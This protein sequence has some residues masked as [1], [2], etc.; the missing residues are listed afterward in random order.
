MH[1]A[2]DAINGVSGTISCMHEIAVAIAAAVEE[3]GV[4]TREIAHSIQQVAQGTEQVSRNI[5]GIKGTARETGLA[6]GQ[7][8]AASGDLDQQS[9]ALR[10][11][12]DRFVG[13]IR[14]A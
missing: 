2:V 8:R 5:V 11:D 9:Q 6:A 13:G 4:A 7:V 1:G 12:V 3:Q 10:S 14:A